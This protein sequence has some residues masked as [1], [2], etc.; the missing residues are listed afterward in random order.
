[1]LLA[2]GLGTF[3]ILGV[4]AL[5][6]NLV[7]EFSVDLAT[8][9]PDMFLLDIQSDQVGGVI[10]TLSARRPAG[11]PEPRTFPVLRAR[12]VGV[13]GRDV[14]L[15][16]YEDVRGRGSLAREYTVTYR[17]RL[18]ANERVV[19]GV[20]LGRHPVG[21]RRGSLDRGEHPRPVPASRSA[22]RCASTSSAA[23]WR[24]TVTQR[25]PRRL[26]RRPRR[27]IHVR[28]PAWSARR[29]AAWLHRHSCAVPY[30][31]SDRAGLQGDLVAAAFPNV[32]VIDGREMLAAIKGVVD[33]VTLAVTVVGTLVVFSGLL[34]LVGAVAM[35]KFRRV[36]EAA[37]LKTLGATRRVIAT[38]LLL[39]YGVLGLLAGAL[40][41]LGAVGADVGAQPL[42]PSTSAYRPAPGTVGDRYRPDR[43][44]RGRWSASPPAGTS[45]NESPWR[46]CARSSGPAWKPRAMIGYCRAPGQ[47]SVELHQ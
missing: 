12:V 30:A 46:P 32:S 13:Q 44:R 24:R 47:G 20:D 28:V 9:A 10:E 7:S 25:A 15:D 39:E 42:T 33:N 11:S 22:T 36:Y 34:I 26:E 41:A 27:R 6:Q 17:S 43:R 23:R 4:R 38:M 14:T 35:T 5:Q 8:D 40:G 18:E 37:I 19:D 29:S 16:D 31:A 45:C 2:V 1:M 21:R 3:F